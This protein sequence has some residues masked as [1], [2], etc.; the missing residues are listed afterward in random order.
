MTST[1]PEQ[2][3]ATTTAQTFLDWTRINSRALTAGAAVVAV[4]ALGYWFYARSKEIQAANADKALVSARESLDKGN[5]PLAQSDLQRVVSRYASTPA[6][7]QA[8]MLLAQIDYDQGKVAEGQKA[9]TD[10]MAEA[11]ATGSEP[12]ARSLVGDGFMQ[13]GKALDAAQAYEAAANS[14]SLPN[15]RQF[16]QA[17][18]ARAYQTAHD[19]AKARQLWSA[20]ADDPKAGPFSGE[21][22]L[23]LGE[24]TAA[25]AKLQ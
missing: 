12:A 1:T 6:G 10:L 7:L 16:Q 19:T 25:A 13:S 4:A 2:D 22:R 17:K 11:R 24:L 23:R 15:E 5:M 18:A 21:A 14:T 9:L 20:L 3:S 8:A